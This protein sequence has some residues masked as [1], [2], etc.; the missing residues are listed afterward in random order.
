MNAIDL[1]THSNKSDGSMT[2]AELIRYAAEKHLSAIALTDHDTIEGLAEA[3]DTAERLRAETG[4]APRVIPGIEFSTEYNGHDI[5]IVGLFIPY[6]DPVF[7]TRIHAFVEAR[8]IR[9]RKMC[10]KLTEH[11][12]PVT[13][14][15]LTAA[16]PDAVITRAHYA[17]FLLEHGY[18]RSMKE[19]FDRYI[20]DHGPCFVPR[21]KITPA[22]AVQMI[23]EVGG[24]AVLAHPIL[25]GFSDDTLRNLVRELK[26]AGLAGIETVYSTYT[27]ADERQIRS[28]AR[29]YDLA[30]SGGSDFHGSNKPDIDLGTGRGHL[31]VPEDL[32]PILEAGRKHA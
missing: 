25:Y 14:E 28:I 2:P 16:Y 23:R 8:D 26:E 5:H 1:H 17:R 7:S 10:A 18:T 3:I 9:N 4:S 13:L 19:A 27:Q 11:G 22:E 6:E 30:I 12:M 20:G 31:F 29:D 15:E 21:E 24:V 32:L